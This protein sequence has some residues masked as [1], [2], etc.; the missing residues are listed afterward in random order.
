MGQAATARIIPVILCGGAGTRLWPL[1]RLDR[2]KPFV[3]IDG[4]ATL[5]QETARRV[6]DPALF[7]PPIVVV[8][9]EFG[10][11]AAA[12]LEEAGVGGA[13]LI[14]EPAARG[15]APAI[16][17]AALMSDPN[18]LLLVLPSDH[19]VRN[20]T[21]FSTAVG[22]AVTAA[23]SGWLVTFGVQPERPETG[24]GYILRGESAAPG[25]SRVESF[26]EKPDAATAALY[27]ADGRYLWNSGIFLFGAGTL[28]AALRE[29]ASY[30]LPAA[31][32]ALAAGR[33]E[34]GSIH[35]ER[36]H[37][38]RSPSQSIDH[39]VMEKSDRV[40]VVPVDMGWSDVGSWEALHA[41]AEHDAQGNAL[42]GDVV[43]IDSQGSLVRSEG[44]LVVGVGVRDMV[45]VATER[46]VLIVPR[47]ESQRVKE[48]VEILAR[49]G[50]EPPQEL[51]GGRRTGDG[52]KP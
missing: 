15:T 49:R 3:S 6:G 25:A 12:Q 38:A 48:A 30:I 2:P 5:F 9:E 23:R 18:D 1:S 21:A 13:R 46:S 27:L 34:D 35:P 11:T 41:A 44:P 20:V 7:A 39:A 33:W 8:A 4:G 40:A 47:G 26:V 14:L 37:F 10:G 31:E 45:I 22:E 43:M 17:T 50:M 32:A 29:H 52:P 19:V 28:I 24:Y 51:G 36:G 16:G 42:A